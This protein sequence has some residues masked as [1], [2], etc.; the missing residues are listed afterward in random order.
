MTDDSYF[1]ISEMKLSITSL[2][3]I[4]KYDIIWIKNND[5]IDSFASEILKYEMSVIVSSTEKPWAILFTYPIFEQ[6]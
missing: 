5:M 3:I 6:F 2:Y 4:S 1:N